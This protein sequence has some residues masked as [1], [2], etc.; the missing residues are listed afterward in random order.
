MKLDELI[1]SK[2]NRN[3]KSW[4]WLARSVGVHPGTLLGIKQGRRNNFGLRT[5][6]KIAKVLDFDMNEFKKLEE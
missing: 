2:L 3:N 4:L 1:Q 6:I 5:A